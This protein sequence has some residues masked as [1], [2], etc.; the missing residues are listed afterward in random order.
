MRNLRQRRDKKET[1]ISMLNLI[2]VIFTMLIF[3]MVVTTFNNYNQFN[4][5]LPEAKADKIEKDTEERVE[6]VVSANKEYFLKKGSNVKKVNIENLSAELS[7]LNPAQKEVIML[8]ADKSLEYEKIIE[9]IAKLKNSGV[10]NVNLNMQ[11]NEHK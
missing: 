7:A 10:K 2:D 3:F 11:V 9:M 1:G 4:L 8:T 5:K 6:V